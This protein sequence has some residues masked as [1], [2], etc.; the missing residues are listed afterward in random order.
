MM[1]PRAGSARAPVAFCVAA[2]VARPRAVIAAA[3]LLL[4]A[5]I[6]Y[7][8]GHFA[9]T[10][11]AGALIAP[12]VPW[13]QQEVAL[14]AAFP[15]FTD[16]MLVIVDGATPELAER[17]AAALAERMT[18]DTAHF[19]AVMRPDGGDFFARNGML[20]GSTAEVQQAMAAL[21]EAQPLLGPLASDPSLRGIAGALSTALTGVEQGAASLD[22]ID[23]PMRDLAAALDQSV[24][25][26]A[27]FFSWSRLFGAQGGGLAAPTRRLIIAQTQ[28][29]YG[30]LMPGEKALTAMRAEAVRL[31][32]DSAH[33]I[34]VRATGEVP[35]ADEEF[36][37]LQDNIGLVGLVMLGAMLITLWFAT[38]S[39]RIVVA[40]IMTIAAGL[41]MTLA[42]GLAAVGA[43]N[44]ISIAF[45]PLFVGLGVDFGIQLSVR[46]NAERH[47]GHG[48]REALIRAGE[49]LGGSLALAAGAV[50][51]GFGAFL[52]TDYTGI[53]ELGII[54]GLGMLVSFLISI[55]VLPAALVLLDPGAPGAEVGFAKG[56]AAD[57]YLARHRGAV[58]WAFALSM[59]GSIALL[60]LVA[61]DFNPLHLRDPQAPAMRTL[62]D[63]TR[64]PLRTP[65]VISVLTPSAAAAQALAARLA[66]LPEVAQ[67]VSIDSLVP[68]DQDTKLA[69][70]QDAN[71]LLDLTLNP[72]STLPPPSD[73]E[74]IAALHAL[75]PQLRRVRGASEGEAADH[76]RA[77]ASALDAVA[78]ASPAV[79]SRAEAVLVEPLKEML[80]QTR[81]ALTAEPIA[82]ETIPPEV[83]RNWVAADGRAQVKV[84][85]KGDLSDNATIVRFTKAVRA[86][87]PGATGLPVSTQEAAGTVAWSFVQAGV[88]ALVLVSLLLLAVLR[89]VREVAFTLAPVVLSGF[90]TLGS[91]VLIGQPINFAN[92]IAFPLLFGV[93]VA[94][95]IYFVMAWRG[96]ET[97]LLQ[98]SL[99]RAVLF[100]AIAT[101]TA[102]G[103]LWLSAHPGTA[104]MGKL[105]M[106]SLAWT[107]VC[108]LIFE[109]ALLGPPR[110][111]NDQVPAGEAG[112]I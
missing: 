64:D 44:L 61:F 41:A 5:A 45:V 40:I 71:L 28:L 33:G 84:F 87:A 103:S 78:A 59:A 85:P 81:A 29:D 73:A 31:A 42:V 7:V 88:I 98:S 24:K 68:A 2:S 96:G 100:S 77:L 74:T 4:G 14:G 38:R 80:D 102:F 79:R 107:L 9:M 12:S 43:L 6:F 48:A 55:T 105:L 19:R 10:T 52:P 92:I 8:M 34:S 67:A 22:K 82:R 32:L 99:A 106:I 70:I 97:G 112:S 57:A 89:D 23:R 20:Y 72:L 51:L 56:A 58:L 75:A 13:K 60:P 11:N 91:C 69:A 101:G 27:A 49:A 66:A 93:G 30:A 108:A 37:T 104:S 39:V 63:L 25:G 16:S 54:A 109:P 94:F 46:F 1:A 35:L 76:A 18:A 65:N 36:A 83:A 17:G 50:F 21:I 95:H 15:Q 53:A 26:K 3:L 86:A 47:A 90:L 110:R 111:K 62:T